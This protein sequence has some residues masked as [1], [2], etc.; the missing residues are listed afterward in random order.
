M[1][2]LLQPPSSKVL[3]S[4]NRTIYIYFG[5][6]AKATIIGHCTLFL[7]INSNRQMATVYLVLLKSVTVYLKYFLYDSSYFFIKSFKLYVRKTNT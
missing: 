1:H 2:I 6:A 7:W 4:V 5:F 3:N